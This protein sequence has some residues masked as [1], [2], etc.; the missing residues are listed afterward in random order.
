[1][2]LRAGEH[3]TQRGPSKW[4]V[5][6]RDRTYRPQVSGCAVHQP[7]AGLQEVSERMSEVVPMAGAGSPWGLCCCP[8]HSEPGIRGLWLPTG[9]W[10]GAQPVALPVSGCGPVLAPLGETGPFIKRGSW[11]RSRPPCGL[12]VGGSRPHPTLRPAGQCCGAYG[13]SGHPEQGT[14][15]PLVPK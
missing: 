3:C 15:E 6:S 10:P 11:S 12:P 14:Q 9:F 5:R 4:P 7:T 8:R 2:R 13:A 1:M